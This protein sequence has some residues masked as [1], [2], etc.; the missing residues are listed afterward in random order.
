ME[1]LY[2]PHDLLYY[3]YPLSHCIFINQT[4]LFCFVWKLR[5]KTIFKGIN[6]YLAL[7][8][9]SAR[10]HLQAAM[11]NKKYPGMYIQDYMKDNKSIFMSCMMP[12][13][14]TAL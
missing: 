5:G 11:S 3:L 4:S 12:N 7:Y 13:C 2:L 9:S 8:E 6:Y 10:S 14:L 1:T